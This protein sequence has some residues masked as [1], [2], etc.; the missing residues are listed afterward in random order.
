M[1]N[2][3]R[4]VG[5]M[6]NNRRQ[7]TESAQRK[8][9]GNLL[10][11]ADVQLERNGTGTRTID[12]QAN[13]GSIMRIA[14]FNV[15]LYV[16]AAVFTIS[17]FIFLVSVF[18]PA[19]TRSGKKCAQE[20]TAAFIQV[21]ECN[22]RSAGQSSEIANSCGG[23]EHQTTASEACAD[24][25]VPRVLPI[26]TQLPIW[27]DP[28]MPK[29]VIIAA[30]DSMQTILESWR[31]TRKH[32]LILMLVFGCL[33]AYALP[34]SS[35]EEQPS[36]EMTTIAE[37]SGG[38]QSLAGKTPVALVFTESIGA[39]DPFSVTV[40]DSAIAGEALDILL[41][42][43]V[44]RQGEQVDMYQYQYEEYRFIFE[45]AQTCAFGFLPHSYF[46]YD[47]Q[48]YA[49]GEN[50]LRSLCDF[51]HEM[52]AEAEPTGAPLSKWYADG[53]VL[54]TRFVDNGDEA[55]SL[56]ELTLTAGGETL[57]GAIE[58]AYDV[59]SIEKQP[60]GYV[61]CYTGGDFY[62]HD[63]LCR[64]LVTVEDGV[65]IITDMA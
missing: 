11:C 10:N 43:S 60:D 4:T 58:G 51:L 38:L 40:D 49:L 1:Q 46:C 35:A 12:L 23:T 30:E 26:G 50:R 44:C 52:A 20:D 22:R 5:F 24:G 48:N 18:A 28:K 15:L 53:A 7:I 33:A 19:F 25:D 55:R 65:M 36:P 21:T 39:S 13:R 37:L 3:A 64:S 2:C 41:N 61:I 42:A 16:T 56:T 17:S 31:R 9:G 63:T 47:G 32:C 45:D 29:R 27:H 8:R 6:R 62:K 14:L 59:R 34:R 54:E 57:T